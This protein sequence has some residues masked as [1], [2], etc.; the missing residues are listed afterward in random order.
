MRQETIG[1]CNLTSEAVAREMAEGALRHSQANVALA[2]TGLA[3]PGGQDGIP[4]GTI[5]FAW[6]FTSGH[7]MH[8]FSE[9]KRSNGERNEVRQA[10]AD[11]A[12]SRIWHYHQELLKKQQASQQ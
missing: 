1:R 7:G 2:T 3:G 4:A 6:A 8:V 12:I 10:S 5:C 11:Y 9:T